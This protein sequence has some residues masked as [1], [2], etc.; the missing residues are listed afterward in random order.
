MNNQS[1]IETNTVTEVEETPLA[2]RINWLIKNTANENSSLEENYRNIA[3]AVWAEANRK[4]VKKT[5]ESIVVNYAQGNVELTARL[6]EAQ[7]VIRNTLKKM[8]HGYP[9]EL[10]WAFYRNNFA[11][12]GLFE[13][14]TSWNYKDKNITFEIQAGTIKLSPDHV[15]KFNNG[16]YNGDKESSIEIRYLNND[17]IALA[18]MV[19]KECRK[20]AADAGEKYLYALNKEKAE[21]EQKVIALQRDIDTNKG[22]KPLKGKRTPKPKFVPTNS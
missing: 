14:G 2:K 3:D 18:Q 6:M 19:R 1:I 11:I 7:T 22:M 16:N 4:P 17:P 12:L 20:F 21:L 5:A 8:T 15:L 13:K 9:P 10:A